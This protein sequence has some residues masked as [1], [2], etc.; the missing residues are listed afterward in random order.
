MRYFWIL[1]AIKRQHLHTLDTLHFSTHFNEEKKTVSLKRLR[2]TQRIEMMVK[3]QQRGMYDKMT[4]FWIAVDDDRSSKCDI[5]NSL[6]KYIHSII[7]TLTFHMWPYCMFFPLVI[8]WAMWKF[9]SMPYMW[10]NWHMN[11]KWS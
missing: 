4:P 9:K 6:H 8:M 11:I 1:S 2:H 5:F 7:F 3:M 10:K